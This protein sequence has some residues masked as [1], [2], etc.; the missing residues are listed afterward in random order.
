MNPYLG[1]AI[2]GGTLGGSYGLIRWMG[3][4]PRRHG[5]TV[6]VN[7]ASKVTDEF[8]T[9]RTEEARLNA[10][11]TRRDL[12]ARARLHAAPVEPAWYDRPGKGVARR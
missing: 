9:A 1:M 2:L 5:V 3:T 12:D 8:V 7:V 10:E 11:K 4:Q 6:N